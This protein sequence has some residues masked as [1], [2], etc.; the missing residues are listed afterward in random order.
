MVSGKT[1]DRGL[2]LTD[3]HASRDP[4]LALI[5]RHAA[6]NEAG[7]TVVPISARAKI[8]GN[9]KQKQK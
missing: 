7:N 6:R 8:I 5:D 3:C 4:G 1:R 2:A 9:K